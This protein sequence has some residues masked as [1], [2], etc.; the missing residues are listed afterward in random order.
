MQK[1][2][3]KYVGLQLESLEDR[4]CPSAISIVGHTMYV[5]G[6]PGN[7]VVSI[8]DN[9][10]GTITATIDARSRTGSNINNIVVNT[11]R[12]DDTMTYTLTGPL[13]RSQ[14]LSVNLGEGT[15]QATLD[16][17]QGAVNANLG[18]TVLGGGGNDR[19]TAQF[20]RF[21]RSNLNCRA[22]LGNG[23]DTFD[24]T[25]RGAFVN[26]S[27]ANFNVSGGLGNDTVAFH[28]NA[29]AIDVDALSSLYF[30]VFGAQGQDNISLDY[31]GQ[32]RGKLNVQVSGDRDVDTLNANVTLN[33]GSTGQ[34][35]AMVRGGHG[36]DVMSLRLTDQSGSS[37]S[38]S[39]SNVRTLSQQ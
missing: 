22:D 4:C 34:L 7:N 32:V 33:S 17:S 8:Q 19:V 10:R 20:G 24:A 2:R 37:G 23:N 39:M 30:R 27:R 6:D 5:M 15:D 35:D 11:G 14:R 9:G 12:G 1:S 29:T 21:D 25:L 28:A 36:T 16:F 3:T 18:L 26:R 13:Q 38:S 31:A